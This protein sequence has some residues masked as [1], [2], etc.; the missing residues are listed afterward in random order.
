MPR[1]P[2][3]ITIDGIE[4]EVTDKGGWN[5][6]AYAYVKWVLDGERERVAVRESK[7]QVWRFWTARD[8]VQPASSYRGQDA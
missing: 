2:K 8:R 3:P 5:M 1:K 7:S 6:D 4:Y